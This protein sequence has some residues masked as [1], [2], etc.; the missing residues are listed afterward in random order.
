MGKRVE[1]LYLPLAYLAILAAPLVGVAAEP[2]YLETSAGG[3]TGAYQAYE[4]NTPVSQY[5]RSISR[6]SPSAGIGL[7]LKPWIALEGEYDGDGSYTFDNLYAYPSGPFTE[8]EENLIDERL[9]AVT[10]RLG[11]TLA[12]P[13]GWRLVLAPGIEYQFLQQTV[14]YKQWYTVPFSV[15][16]VVPDPTSHMYEFWRPDF[17]ARLSYSM[18]A[19][20][21]AFIGYRFFESP[22]KK[23]SC[24][25]G[26]M[27]A[28]W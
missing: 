12:L 15:G 13:K 8:F 24:F 28:Y 20:F 14:E 1:S 2:V 5:G 18:A 26:G 4:A 7:Q 17:D 27:G 9:Q 23:L 3:L 19:H 6:F 21:S 16:Q 11:I 22:G 10:T 25:S